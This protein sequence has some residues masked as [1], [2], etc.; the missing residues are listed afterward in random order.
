MVLASF[1]CLNNK[2]S[3]SQKIAIQFNELQTNSDVSI[4]A[5]VVVTEDIVWA[6]GADGTVL[7]TINGGKS[8]STFQIPNE[9]E[10]DFRCIYAW[11]ETKAMVFGIAGPEF[12]YLTEDGGKT[13]EVVYQDSTTGL[14]FNSLVFA[15]ELNGLAISDQ[16]DGKPFVIRTENGGQ[17]WKK[18]DSVPE[19]WAGEANF[20][21]SNT[22]IEYL[23]SGHAWFVTGGIKSRVFYSSDFGKS[24]EHTEYLLFPNS[25]SSGIFSVAFKNEKEGVIVGGTYDRPE[26][27]TNIAAYTKDG[28]LSWKPS[29]T[30]P[31]EYRSCVQFFSDGKKDIVIAIGKTGC[32]IS[33]DNGKT[34]QFSNDNGYYTLSA[35]PGTLSGYA[36]GSGGRIAKFSLK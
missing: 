36:A 8:W 19:V 29:E 25:P 26:L 35:I 32:D 5:L 34:W 23:P 28:G 14:F 27:N 22:C 18:V 12:G 24:W 10:N 4:R 2:E 3:T 6:S 9:P 15:D 13:W 17:D 16:V 20:A 31:K 7:N 21:A 11:S 30:M 33:M 1:S